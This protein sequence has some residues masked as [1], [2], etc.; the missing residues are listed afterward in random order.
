MRAI[1]THLL[2]P[3]RDV[4]NYRTGDVAV[5][6]LLLGSKTLH[7]LLSSEGSPYI[8]TVCTAQNQCCFSFSLLKSSWALINTATEVERNPNHFHEWTEHFFKGLPIKA[9]KIAHHIPFSQNHSESFQTSFRQLPFT[10]W[11]KPLHWFSSKGHSGFPRPFERKKR[12]IKAY[13]LKSLL[14]LQI[15]KAVYRLQCNC[16]GQVL[17]LEGE[18]L[19]R[20]IKGRQEKR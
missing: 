17:P 14:G 3:S 10:C 19:S 8:Y 1:K 6:T 7:F 18:K 15:G 12:H 9:M 16:R 11:W 13:M 4:E 2:L 20:K 5:W